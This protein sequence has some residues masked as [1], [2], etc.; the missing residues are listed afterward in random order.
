MDS[1]ERAI[2]EALARGDDR[3]RAYREK[4]YRSVLAA[5]ERANQADASLTAE[6]IQRRKDVLKSHITAIEQEFIPAVAADSGPASGAA[7]AVEPP[8]APP[9]VEQ[10][11]PAAP[12]VSAVRSDP[13]LRPRPP[14]GEIGATADD[15]LSQDEVASGARRRRPYPA[16]FVAVVLVAAF[17]M[18]AWWANETGLFGRPDTSVPN[19]PRQL[20][21][22]DFTPDPRPS[23]GLPATDEQ[24]DWVT[25]F[26]P[27]NAATATAPSGASADV[28]E[29]DSGAFLIVRSGSAGEAVLFDVPAE[30]LRQ[31]AGGSAVFDIVARAEEGNETQMSISCSF[32]ELGDCGRKRYLVGYERADYL[33][34]IELPSGSPGAAGTIAIVPDVSN[35]SRALHIFEIR[36]ASVP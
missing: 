17:A 26:T 33:F 21:D 22:E 5:L 29:D 8:R 27:A 13:T 18:G 15:R 12:P 31:L 34:D 11:P 30:V 28:A 3:D 20:E 1:I 25:I 32:G 35:G 6:A 7:P 36:V 16:M 4:V 14:A 9:G 24:R 2:R 19:P 10:A 23:P